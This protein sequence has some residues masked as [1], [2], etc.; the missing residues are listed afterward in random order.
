[1]IFIFVALYCEAEPLIR[2]YGLKA[3]GRNPFGGFASGDGRMK[4]ILTG[5]GKTNAAA[6]VSYVCASDNV[7]PSDLLVNIGT[8]AGGRNR[9]GAY[10]INAVRDDDTGR[11]YYPDMLYDTGLPESQVTTVSVVA[12]EEITSS[13]GD[14]LWEMEASG[15][16]DAARIFMPPHRVALIKA[17]SDRGSDD[18]ADITEEILQNTI[19]SSIDEISHALDVL[20]AVKTDKA[21]DITADDEAELFKCSETMRQDL[22]KLLTYARNSG[23]DADKILNDMRSEELIPA[24]DR[25]GGKE[26]LN[27]FGR[28]LL[29]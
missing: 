10:L 18:A 15:F 21:E 8:C 5:I 7:T 14:M 9:D 23:I 16:C 22:I 19:D 26:A 17:V 24:A 20:V 4:V 13:D 25:R 12:T 6:A 29:E 3:D 11:M 2:R 27:E 1:M 28:R